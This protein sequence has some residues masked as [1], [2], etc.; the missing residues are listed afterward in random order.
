MTKCLKKDSKVVHT[1]E[2]KNSFEHLKSLL[3][4]A[5]ILQYPDFSKPFLLTT[6]ASNFAIGA[7]LS[8]G[9]IPNDKPIA[10]ALRTLSTSETRYSTIEKELLAIVWACKYFR[11]YLFGHKFTILTNHKPLQWLFSLKE[12][13]SRLVRWRLKLEE[14]DYTVQYKKGKTNQAADALSRNPISLNAVE[15]ESL[16]N[17]PGDANEIIDDFLRNQNQLPNLD[18]VNLDEILEPCINDQPPRINI[19]SDYLFTPVG[20]QQETQGVVSMPEFT[21]TPISNP[22][23]KPSTS[24]IDNKNQNSLDVTIFP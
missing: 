19:L 9:I 20:N 18:N 23:S 6:D 12:P 21:I 15:T 7:V 14:F 11:P 3:I 17:N 16:I 5:P 8:Q 24:K 10:Y 4:N 2:F 13:N 22:I 1:P